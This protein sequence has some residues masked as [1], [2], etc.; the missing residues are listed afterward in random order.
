MV[1]TFHNHGDLAG[2]LIRRIKYLLYKLKEKFDLICYSDVYVQ[3]GKKDNEP[4]ELKVIVGI[5]GQDI[6]YTSRAEDPA[7][8]IK[9]MY[10]RLK[11]TLSRRLGRD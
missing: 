4:L 2:K 11:R 6:V 7:L 3:Q 5:P 1:I 10:N 9:K 8:A